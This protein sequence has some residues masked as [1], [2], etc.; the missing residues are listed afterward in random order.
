MPERNGACSARVSAEATAP[1]RI[2][3]MNA[4]SRSGSSNASGV[5]ISSFDYHP[6]GLHLPDH[7][8]RLVGRRVVVERTQ[9]HQVLA[10]VNA[11]VFAG[12]RARRD[13]GNGPMPR[14]NAHHLA[15]LRESGEFVLCRGAE[16]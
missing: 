16:P 15:H 12:E 2:A 7:A 6:V 1:Q 10:S 5:G 9:R 8:Q 13:V 3:S 4:S 14:A 11:G